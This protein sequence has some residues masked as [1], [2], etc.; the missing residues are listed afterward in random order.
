MKLLQFPRGPMTYLAA[1][2]ISTEVDG[3]LS[4]AASTLSSTR[5]CAS[6]AVGPNYNGVPSEAQN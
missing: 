1:G 2:P 5:A 3:Q 6:P 4:I